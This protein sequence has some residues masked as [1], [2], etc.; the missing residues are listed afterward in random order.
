MRWQINGEG[1]LEVM[2]LIKFIMLWRMCWH[3]IHGCQQLVIGC[4]CVD[5]DG[6]CGCHQKPRITVHKKNQT[7]QVLHMA[8][9]KTEV[10]V[11]KTN[12]TEDRWVTVN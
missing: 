1:E 8:T 3:E 12:K 5:T 10:Y 7:C 11:K 2:E 6:P 4:S 9:N